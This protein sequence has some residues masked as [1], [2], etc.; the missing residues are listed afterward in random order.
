MK[1]TNE[2][3]PSVCL[4]TI[5]AMSVPFTDGGFQYGRVGNPTRMILEKTLAQLEKAKFCSVFSSG[6]SAIAMFLLTLHPGDTVLCHTVMYEGT[7]RLFQNVFNQLD[8]HCLCV[9][10][11][12]LK[13]MESNMK[14]NVKWIFFESPTNPM[15]E[16]LDIRSICRIAHKHNVKVAVD[17]TLAS[18]AIQKPIL[19]GADVVIES[20]TKAI[21]GHSD[22]IGGLVATNNAEI[23][24]KI[25]L[26]QQTIG[27]ILSPFDCFLVLRGLK[28]LHIRVD[29]QQKN[30]LDIV[31]FLIRHKNIQHINFPGLNSRSEH[32]FVE[33]QMQGCGSIVSFHLKRTVNPFTFLKR[34]RLITIAQSFGGAETIIQ[35][36]TR[37]MNL[38]LTKNQRRELGIDDWFFRLSI[39]LENP[40]DIINDLRRALK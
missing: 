15:L 33:K 22:V 10:M 5:F 4:S 8:I 36:P 27:A 11:K 26:L 18:P 20:I 39:G 16:V 40:K 37:M 28:T 21:N 30:T 17:N 6:S 19:C 13:L 14:P 32:Q 35:Q 23:S 7:Q 31:D 9:D 34:L 1:Q 38:S 29:A 2:I 12:N 25:T 3:I 24:K